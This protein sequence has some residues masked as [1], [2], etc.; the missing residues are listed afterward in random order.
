MSA[1]TGRVSAVIRS[2]SAQPAL[3]I[4][5]GPDPRP[6]LLPQSSAGP[7]LLDPRVVR[8]VPSSSRSAPH[9]E[10]L[11]PECTN[12]AADRPQ[13]TEL[14]VRTPG[15]ACSVAGCSPPGGRAESES[16]TVLAPCSML[17]RPVSIELID[18]QFSHLSD[19]TVKHPLPVVWRGASARNW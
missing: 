12:F 17:A 10:S 1:S 14:R 4:V 5:V 9:S 3:R 8:E 18:L 13:R 19:V 11:G 7:L 2:V 6:V 15:L 16:V